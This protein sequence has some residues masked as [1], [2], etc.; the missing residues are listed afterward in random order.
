MNRTLSEPV[1][2]AP[3]YHNKSCCASSSTY[4]PAF[5][6]MTLHCSNTT[7]KRQPNN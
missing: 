6:V 3:C 5:G 1:Q 2:L 4:L 7:N